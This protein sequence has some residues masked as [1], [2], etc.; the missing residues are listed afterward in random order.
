MEASRRLSRIVK[1]ADPTAKVKA[2]RTR[3]EKDL[4]RW[5]RHHGGE[6]F[7]SPWSPDHERILGKI[8]LAMDKGGLFALAMPR[9]GGK[10]TILKWVTAYVLLT[11]RRKYVVVIAATAE[12]AQVIVDFIRQQITESDTLHAHYPQVTTYARATDGKAIKARYQLRADGK[13]SGIHWSRPHWY[14]PRSQPR[15]ARHIPATGPSSR[16]TA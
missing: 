2:A 4:P 6:A 14:S 8:G 5:L 16:P 1:H 3:L 10:S 7:S 11:G 12:L 15:T 13:T 9:A